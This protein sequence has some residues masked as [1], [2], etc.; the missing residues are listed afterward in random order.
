MPSS[1][2]FVIG[3]LI[4]VGAI[5]IYLLLVALRNPVLVKIGLRN[6]PRRPAQSILIVIGL[7]LSTVIIIS[8]LAT[9]DTLTYSVRNH[10]IKAYGKIDEI[11]AP[12]IISELANLSRQSHGAPATAASSGSGTSTAAG[13]TGQT[14]SD[15]NQLM[16][17]GLTSVLTVLG[18]GLPSISEER[19][20]ALRREATGDPQIDGV[21]AS[22]IFPTIIHDVNSGQGEPL[23]FIFAVDKDYNSQFG[24]TTINGQQADM[25]S[26]QTGVGNIFVGASDLFN[27]VQNAGSGLGLKNATVSD[28]AVATAAVGAAL[29]AGS[30]NTGVD[31]S[32]IHISLDTLKGLGIDTTPLE[33]QGINSI[34]LDALGLNDARLRALGIPTTTVSLKSLGIS[35]STTQSVTNSLVNIFNLNTLG[36][37]I[38][39]TLSQFG[40]Q[41]RQGDVYLNRLGAE[42]LDAQVGDV[43][44]IYIGPIPIPFRVKAIVDQAGPMGALAPVVMLRLDEAQ[45]LLF[46]NGKVNNVLISNRGDAVTGM[47]YTQAV[48]DRLHVL[49]LDPQAVAAVAAILRRPAVLSV[50]D[51]HASQVNQSSPRDLRGPRFIIS[52]FQNPSQAEEYKAKIK[53]LPA[54]LTGA[55]ASDQLRSLLADTSVRDWLTSLP[56]TAKDA[57]DLQNALDALNQFDTL[58]PLSKAN[59][60]KVADIGGVVFTSVFSIFGFF[61]ILAG[62]LL[63]FLIFVMMAAERRSEMGMARAIG[64]QRGHLIQMFVTEGVV[65]DLLAAALGVLLGLGISY[66]MVDFIGR[67]F[68]Q[69]TAR[70][71]GESGLFQIQ[72]HTTPITLILA[73]CLGVLF[74]FVVVTIA[75]WRT[76][77]LNIVAAIRGLPEPASSNR[78][79]GWS[80]VA[81]LAFGP[82]LIAAGGLLAYYGVATALS[83]VLAGASF[84]L[85]GACFLAGWWL[86]RTTLRSERIQRFVYTSIG[87]GLLVIWGLPWDGWIHSPSGTA[88]DLNGP[89]I[90]LSFA[91]TGPMIILGAILVV[92]FNADAWTWAISRLLGGIGALTPVLKTAIAYPLSARF[93]TGMTMLMFAIVMTT[94]T[95]MAVVIA[96][97][98]TIVAPDSQ[99]TAGFDISASSSLLSIFAPLYD[100]QG[101][102]ANKPDFPQKDIAVVGSVASQ[103]VDAQQVTANSPVSTSWRHVELIGV[104]QGYLQQAALVYSFKL[105]AP[106]YASDAAVWQA[107]QKRDDVA[108]ITEDM[109]PSVASGSG[110]T[111]NDGGGPSHE[112]YWRNRLRFSGIPASSNT[113]P[114]LKVALRASSAVTNSH[115]VQ[116]IGVIAQRTTLAGNGMWINAQTLDIVMGKAIQPNN[117]YVKVTPGADVHKVATA[118]ER[119][120]LANALYATVMTESFAQAQAV[121]RGILQL[122]QGFLALGLLV[123]IA[124]LGVIST[125]TVV[126][127]RQEV[128]MLRAIG[129]QPRM[130]AL[131]FLM[132]SSFIALTGISVGAIAGVV[133]GR[134]MVDIFFA[135]LADGRTFAPPWLEIGAIILFAYLFS[136]LTTIVPAYQAAHIYPAEALR[137]E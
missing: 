41:L 1:S 77:R 78:R 63:I 113:L 45:K 61:S 50:I 85:T 20:Q 15:L 128:G 30:A 81:H 9:G 49:A 23:G 84:I 107:L 3:L 102:I 4:G 103:E 80:S 35:S 104:N 126:E 99:R 62:V 132:E 68:N 55:G 120:F 16:Q 69:V 44:E 96:A 66:A 134:N 40:L 125:R 70:L 59:V 7:T 39:R 54:A 92:M 32:K 25:A 14:T 5:L 98:Q 28:I 27:L 127:R 115:T 89:W 82:L 123:G 112:P 12:P 131:S 52:L 91:L 17:G 119:D 117:F 137:Y 19:Y 47:D 121:I 33:Q 130:V 13:N 65:Y 118:I 53:L 51:Q 93:R 122:F 83:I 22:I 76:S 101:A 97:T 31:L 86:Q 38:D 37:E 58:D 57:G 95:V 71:T 108:V 8:A 94:V 11:I 34:S 109:V 29:T 48:S 135:V 133:L 64:M 10:A 105:R 43:L 116:V 6:I 110:Q 129:F 74:T 18:G 46:M 60:V 21:A 88:L 36:T 90:L 24:L 42:Q 136:L 87:V 26:L 106:G 111:A 67:L 2:T 73:Y 72:F 114:E 56:L 75:S 124:A 79:S 100:L